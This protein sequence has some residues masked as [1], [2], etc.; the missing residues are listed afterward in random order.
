[1]K[2]TQL[3]L[4]FGKSLIRH[5]RLLPDAAAPMRRPRSHLRRDPILEKLCAELIRAVKCRGLTVGVFWNDRLRTTAG[6]ACWSKKMILLNPRL[7]EI[8]PSEVQRTLRHELAHFVAQ[9][10]AGRRRIDPHGPEWREAC[11][12]LG[13]PR[14]AR[15]HNLPFKRTRMERKHFYACKHCGTVLARVR[16]IT[17][18]VACLKCCRK[19]NG[20]RYHDAFRFV[21]AADREA[22]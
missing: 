17:G 1:M 7:I 11:R 18:R 13:I 22:A 21:A 19:H 3:A 9:F 15:C 16:P 14:E 20:G 5:L 2:H 4:N 12:D 6:M 8:S 10:R